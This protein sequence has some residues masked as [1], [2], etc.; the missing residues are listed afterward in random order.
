MP[1]LDNFERALQT[2]DAVIRASGCEIW[3]GAEPTFTNRLSSNAEW[4]MDALG[5]EKQDRAEQLL[6]ALT[7]LAGRSSEGNPSPPTTY[8]PEGG[9]ILRSLGR[10]YPGEECARWSLGYFR[11]R[12]GEP[13][14][15]GPPDP[16]LLAAEHQ[17]AES[18]QSVD[19]AAWQAALEEAFRAQG[20]ASVAIAGE[21]DR[22]LV[23]VEGS[24]PPRLDAAHDPRLLR[25]SFHTR[26]IPVTGWVDDLARDGL[27]L[28]MLGHAS[29]RHPGVATCELPAFPTVSLFLRVAHAISAA[30]RQCGVTSLCLLGLPPPVDASVAWTTITPDPAVVEINMAPFASATDFAQHVELLDRAAAAVGLAPYRSYFNGDV[31]DSGGGGQI[32]FGGPTALDSPFLRYPHL[33][34]RLIRYVNHHPSLSYFF[35][36]PYIG[37][38]GQSVRTDEIGR[39]YFEELKLSLKLLS[40][41]PNPTPELIWRSYAPFLTDASGNTHRAELNIEKL[42]NPFLPGRG[43]LGL[44]EFRALGMPTHPQRMTAIATLLRS[45]LA[46]L[47]T[48]PFDDPLIDWGATLHDRFALP[49]YLLEDLRL[50]LLDLHL[51]GFGLEPPLVDV[52]LDDEL[53]KMT[54]LDLGSAQLHIKRGLDFWPLVGDA[55]SQEHG[56]SRLID[57]S[58][59]RLELLLTGESVAELARWRVSIE[60]LAVPLRSE[61]FNGVPARV[62]GVRYRRFLPWTGLHPT[63]APLQSLMVVLEHPEQAEAHEV[64]IHEWRPDG[65]PYEGLPDSLEE[66]RRRRAAR[67][68]VRKLPAPVPMRPTPRDA[69]SEYCLDLRW[70]SVE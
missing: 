67:V 48:R 1:S 6:R 7:R 52:L 62:I 20:L 58:T 31:A 4:M 21:H 47:A 2:H 19:L 46:R 44:V 3:L 43:C 24:E 8:R 30:S 70:A 63:L 27:F 25:P 5:E 38:S 33:L 35:A 41:V 56:A 57:S 61:F 55:A 51:A 64:T 23:L 49:F 39:E 15:W 9:M 69:L 16:L 54:Q 22:R 66:A 18:P 59:T 53:R 40:A 45:I 12:S 50:V 10:Q 29:P 13:C 42:W 26:P 36:H 14:W 37:S 28:M 17:E 34:P 68:L 32:T 60:N 65:L 11:L